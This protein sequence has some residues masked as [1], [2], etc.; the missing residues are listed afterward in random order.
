MEDFLND[1]PHGLIQ[2][3]RRIHENQAD[4]ALLF[5]CGDAPVDVIGHHGYN[6]A[7]Y[8]KLYHRLILLIEGPGRKGHSRQKKNNHS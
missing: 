2:P 7:L 8:L 3:T 4:C 6:G 1:L 5:R